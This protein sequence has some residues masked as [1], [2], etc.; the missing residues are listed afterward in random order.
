MVITDSPI[1][2]VPQKSPLDIHG[3]ALDCETKPIAPGSQ[4]K[5]NPSRIKTD[6]SALVLHDVALIAPVKVGGQA[7]SFGAGIGLCP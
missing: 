1:G 5:A 2:F 7:L 6:F 4:G 3:G